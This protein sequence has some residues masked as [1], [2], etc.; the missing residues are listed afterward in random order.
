VS[1]V[2]WTNS[3]NTGVLTRSCVDARQDHRLMAFSDRSPAAA[4]HI[5]VRGP[6]PPS[7]S[8]HRDRKA[9]GIYD[10]VV[11]V[12]GAASRQLVAPH[13]WGNPAGRVDT[14][15]IPVLPL[16]GAGRK[17]M[18]ISLTSVIHLDGS[19]LDVCGRRMR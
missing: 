12:S 10:A 11:V 19:M 15:A 13:G 14:P 7:S 17:V 6:I 2:V 9:E 1:V 5:L 8:I 4:K 16:E 18:D 3:L